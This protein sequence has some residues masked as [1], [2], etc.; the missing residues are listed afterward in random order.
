LANLSEYVL[1]EMALDALPD[2][3]SELS[4][5]DRVDLDALAFEAVASAIRPLRGTRG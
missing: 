1:V 4:R 5:W 2:E 3:V